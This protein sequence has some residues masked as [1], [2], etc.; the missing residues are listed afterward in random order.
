MAV[1]FDVEVLA[2]LEAH[3]G[4]RKVA[5]FVGLQQPMARSIS[6]AIASPAALDAAIERWLGI[7][8][9]HGLAMITG[10]DVEE[11]AGRLSIGGRRVSPRTVLV[12]LRAV[13]G[14]DEIPRAPGAPDAEDDAPLTWALLDEAQLVIDSYPFCNDDLWI[15]E[16]RRTHVD[17]QSGRDWDED[18]AAWLDSKETLGR[19]ACVAWFYEGGPNV[20]DWGQWRASWLAVLAGASARLLDRVRADMRG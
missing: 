3:L 5:D 2:A 19:P 6:A 12:A 15:S 8:A 1:V 14:Q 17:R 13:T 18:L 11:R 20:E 4:V 10:A 7:Q 9:R 16:R